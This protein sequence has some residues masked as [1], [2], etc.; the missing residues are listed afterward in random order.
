MAEISVTESVHYS[1]V[2]LYYII[3]NMVNSNIF[4]IKPF[5]SEDNIN[6]LNKLYDNEVLINIWKLSSIMVNG[7]AF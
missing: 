2:S 4:V 3:L 6:A 7:F 5:C 1:E